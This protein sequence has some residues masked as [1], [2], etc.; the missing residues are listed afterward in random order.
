VT[1]TTK[2]VFSICS[3]AE[4]EDKSTTALFV[5]QHP[6]SFLAGGIG[7]YFEQ[8][9]K[10]GRSHPQDIAFGVLYSRYIILG[11]ECIR[12]SKD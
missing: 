4:C 5:L 2:N 1:Q 9:A 3:K 10:A 7:N 6:I 12:D 8:Y 11:V